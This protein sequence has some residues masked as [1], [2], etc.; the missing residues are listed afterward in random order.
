LFDGNLS[1]SSFLVDASSQ[2]VMTTLVNMKV[3]GLERYA[4]LEDHEVGLGSEADEGPG[5]G[6]CV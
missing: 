2:A 4:V 1:G 3:P 6:D 5:Q